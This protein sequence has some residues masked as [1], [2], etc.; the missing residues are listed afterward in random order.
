VIIS[1]EVRN[2]GIDL[3]LKLAVAYRLV[4]R[5]ILSIRVHQIHNGSRFLLIDFVFKEDPAGFVIAEEKLLPE[6]DE[7]DLFD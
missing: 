2:D 4:P 3:R 5:Q 1:L 7:V 6:A